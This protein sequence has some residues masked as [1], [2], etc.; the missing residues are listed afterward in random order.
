MDRQQI[1][2]VVLKVVGTVLKEPVGL[3]ASRAGLAKWDSL[4]HVEIMFALED[5][6][7][8]AF[9]EEE[10]SDLDSVARIIER[11]AARAA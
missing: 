2:P 6:F 8:M 5:A 3:D 9:S 1:E 7:D 11:V 4:K 10:L